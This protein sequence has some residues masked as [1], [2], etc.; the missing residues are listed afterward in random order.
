MSEPGFTWDAAKNE[1]NI[2][3]HG[4]DFQ[5]AALIFKGDIVEAVDDREDYGEVR[6]VALG[7][8]GLTV[9]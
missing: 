9:S 1:T 8:I 4:I 7:L 5:R 2:A 3:K 6:I